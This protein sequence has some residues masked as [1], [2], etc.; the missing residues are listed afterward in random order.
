MKDINGSLEH[1]LEVN[2]RG[3][4]QLGTACLKCPKCKRE[5]DKQEPKPVHRITR[6]APS[7]PLILS[8]IF[9]EYDYLFNER[10][11]ALDMIT[12][13]ISLFTDYKDR[14][15]IY[16]TLDYVKVRLSLPEYNVFE[17]L[18]LQ[19]CG[20]YLDR[21]EALEKKIEYLESNQKDK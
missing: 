1:E 15:D 4:I 8:E 3:S 16:K 19:A 21:V 10:P 17:P 7:R 2:C 18:Y 14:E 12:K 5:L 13:I 20:Y 6:E 11:E 9:D